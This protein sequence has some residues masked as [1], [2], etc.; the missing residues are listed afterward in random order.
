MRSLDSQQDAVPHLL[1]PRLHFHSSNSSHGE[2]RRS[3][4]LL[5][6]ER[7]SRRAVANFRFP[8]LPLA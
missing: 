5:K 6:D 4:R 8:W 2:G 3:K 1:S 7:F